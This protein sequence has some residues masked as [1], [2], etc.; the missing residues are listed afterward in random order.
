[1]PL[2]YLAVMIAGIVL[3]WP[4]MAATPVE[5]SPPIDISAYDFKVHGLVDFRF[6]HADTAQSWVDE[7]LGKFAYGG[8]GSNLFRVDQ[9]AL[10]MQARLNWDW[11][12]MV[13]AKYGNSQENSVGISEAALLFRPVS[14]SAWRFSARLG[15]FMPPISLENTGTAWSSPYTLNSSAINSWVGE[16][17]K[18][19]GGEAQINYQFASG[20]KVNLFGSGFGNNDTAGTLLAWRGW[21]LNDQVTTMNGRLPL[22][23]GNILELFPRQAPQTQPFVEVDNRPG[24]YAGFGLERPELIKFRALYYDNRAKTNA[25]SNGLY[26]WHTRFLSLGL[27]MD[28]P[29][30]MTLIGQGMTGRTQMGGQVGSLFPVDSGFWAESVLLSKAIGIHRLSA[31]Y[32]RFGTNENNLSPQNTNVEQGYALT[33]NY[34]VTLAEYH[35][36]NF[37]FSDIYSNSSSRFILGEATQQAGT[38]WQIAYR[39][40][41]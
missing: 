30:K 38:L 9:A 32:D 8:D 19:F 27:K 18:T 17:L 21:T 35:Q 41:F 39:F 23:N 10:S 37:E 14:T 2:L 12:G 22:P 13:T 1:M 20:D 34:N 6:I 5:I 33:L 36:L 26:G 40:I 11:T 28:L 31:R 29:W 16:E 4:I 25:I 3:S 15:A 7:G 24:Y